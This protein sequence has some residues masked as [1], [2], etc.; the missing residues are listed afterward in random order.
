MRNQFLYSDLK[1]GL[2][3]KYINSIWFTCFGKKNATVNQEFN[4]PIE[5]FVF[6]RLRDDTIK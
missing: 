1:I 6:E 3:R 5:P 4:E 2:I